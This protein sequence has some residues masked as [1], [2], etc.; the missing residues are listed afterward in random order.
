[1][2]EKNDENLEEEKKKKKK[3]MSS[4]V[5]EEVKRYIFEAYE[6]DGNR[7]NVAEKH[8]KEFIDKFWTDFNKHKKYKFLENMDKEKFME[9]FGQME[10]EGFSVDDLVLDRTGKLTEKFSSGMTEEKAIQKWLQWLKGFCDDPSNHMPDNIFHNFA[11]SA[12]VKINPDTCA[13]SQTSAIQSTEDVKRVW[14]MYLDGNNIN[15]GDNQKQYTD[16]IVDGVSYDFDHTEKLMMLASIK[17][18]RKVLP[19]E[20]LTS[21]DLKFPKSIKASM[22]PK[23]LG[24]LRGLLDG[25]LIENKSQLWD[26]NIKKI[27][28]LVV[29]FGNVQAEFVA[30][31]LKQYWDQN[32]SF[33]KFKNTFSKIVSNSI[34]NNLQE[35]REFVDSKMDDFVSSFSQFP[36]YADFLEIYPYDWKALEASNPTIVHQNRKID[37]MM[38]DLR[39]SNSEPEVQAE[40][41]KAIKVE[42]AKLEE[43]K[44]KA[45]IATMKTQEPELAD[46]LDDLLGS[47][48]DFTALSTLKKQTII[49]A[50]KRK[51]LKEMIEKGL[52]ASLNMSDDEY[53]AL[54]DDF[55]DISKTELHI[56]AGDQWYYK[57]KVKKDLI[58]WPF[59]ENPTISEIK[60]W[61]QI[62]FT[63]EVDLNDDDEAVDFFEN[64]DLWTSLYFS[65]D[66]K[67]S[68]AKNKIKLNE[69]YKVKLTKDDWTE[70]E[71]YLSPVWP[72]KDKSDGGDLFLYSDPISVPS[73][74]RKIAIDKWEVLRISPKDQSLYDVE[75]TNKKINLTGDAVNQLLFASNIWEMQAA[76][77]EM[78]KEDTE[79]L[80]KWIEN[81]DTYEDTGDDMERNDLSEDDELAW[82]KKTV[83]VVDEYKAFKK[84]FEELGP[85]D[86]KWWVGSYYYVKVWAKSKLPPKNIGNQRA[87]FKVSSI[88]DSAGTFDVV[89]SG[90]DYKLWEGLEWMKKQLK[91][92]PKTI[93]NFE[94]SDAFGSGNVYT[95]PPLDSMS[96]EEQIKFFKEANIDLPG[97]DVL[98]KDVTF[99]GKNFRFSDSDEDKANGGKIKYFGYT[100]ENFEIQKDENGEDKTVSKKSKVLYEI[101]H[102]GGGFSVKS[103]F[104]DTDDKGKK[105][106]YRYQHNMSYADLILFISEKKLGPLNNDVGDAKKEQIKSEGSKVKN[107]RQRF[108]LGTII[109]VVKMQG[110]KFKE[111]W[112]KKNKEKVD[113]LYN[114]VVGAWWMT[115]SWLYK[116]LW[117]LPGKIGSTFDNLHVAQMLE[118]DNIVWNKI[119][120]YLD[121][122]ENDP[123]AWY[124]Y[125]TY[126]DKILKSGVPK[127]GDPYYMPAMLLAMMKMWWPYMRAAQARYGQGRWV[128][129]LLGNVAHTTYLKK[130]AEQREKVKDLRNKWD[131]VAAELAQNDL[132]KLEMTFIQHNLNGWSLSMGMAIEWENSK[133]RSK[134]FGSEL[135]KRSAEFFSSSKFEEKFQEI[136]KENVSFEFAL[137]EFKK[138]ITSG[139]T[140]KGMAYLKRMA[141]CAS[142]D[143]QWNIFFMALSWVMLSGQMLNTV[144]LD[145]KKI[146]Q[147]VSRARG[148]LP[149]LWTRE[150]KHQTKMKHLFDFITRKDG[151][152]QFSKAMNYHV[153]RVSLWNSKSFF[154]KYEAWWLWNG[155][156]EK[157]MRFLNLDG[158]S[159]DD[160]ENFVNYSDDISMQDKAMLDD[161]RASRSEST[162]EDVDSDVANNF[163]ELKSLV[164]WKSVIQSK[165]LNI[166]KRQFQW[167]NYEKEATEELWNSV[168]KEIPTHNLWQNKTKLRYILNTFFPWFEN[169][170]NTGKKWQFVKALARAQ[171]LARSAQKMR[172]DGNLVAADAKMNE[173]KEIFWYLINGQISAEYNGIPPQLNSALNSFREF[174]ESNLLN[175][176][177]NDIS[178]T[179]GQEY[180]VDFNSPFEYMKKRDYGVLMLQGWKLSEEQREQRILAK[181]STIYLNPV[182]DELHKK[183]ARMWEKFPSFITPIQTKSQM[184]K[185]AKEEGTNLDINQS[186][187]DKDGIATIGGFGASREANVKDSDSNEEK[188]DDVFE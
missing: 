149:W 141:T 77:P 108:S 91:L 50:M 6:K 3:K 103:I 88:N 10:K 127:H 27:K 78:D 49:D 144:D 112:E 139:R 36:P 57:L 122:F 158:F 20:L 69:S 134:Q 124:V 47:K 95:T 159:D 9:I 33:Q 66:A 39:T 116:I 168:A 71:W 32:L 65:F 169:T 162:V 16:R 105:K 82:E 5:V 147:R 117:K 21:F 165:W 104:M 100:Q 68:P 155:A 96:R 157:V 123:N 24:D 166:S 41:R 143:A 161:L 74:D 17:K 26:D 128:K 59:R 37:K 174:F 18:I 80:K 19:E 129:V 62:P 13:I 183:L 8:S 182:I 186:Y 35:W 126:F 148:F 118:R 135:E 23:K 28:N 58:G 111:D 7:N 136:E 164:L 142:W 102:S 90:C 85:G 51:K 89:M 43:M 53:E 79:K 146:F 34:I 99:D 179:L 170:Y 31:G 114:H 132:I 25:F 125:F 178:A 63:V 138:F 72:V 107:K 83:D 29:S 160:V 113:D 152:Q 173:V 86:Q 150:E 120:E 154:S 55:F 175:I 92:S 2:V 163:N 52:P 181:D 106:R 22:E 81:L 109:D 64:T 40:N 184:A 45:Y 1:M 121:V 130:Q 177:E 156:G 54:I 110:S 145:T 30:L 185:Q 4:S 11:S 115:K 84:R 14:K 187:S 153:S 75:V 97:I 151:N 133:Q 67:N 93:D 15:L 171:Q 119:K 61:K 131:V 180:V 38:K 76:K 70:F 44:R 87:K 137:F 56:A 94:K 101:N 73:K 42:Q 12:R 176:D 188:F 48:F 60:N 167:E 172:K 46:V 140:A 98:E